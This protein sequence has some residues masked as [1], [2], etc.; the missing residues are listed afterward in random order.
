MKLLMRRAA[1]V[2]VLIASA[3]S[4]ADWTGMQPRAAHAA[5]PTCLQTDYSKPPAAP[6][7]LRFG[8]DPE[9]AGDAGAV[10]LPAVPLNEAAV[11]AAVQGLR[12]PGAPLV[13]RLNRLFESDGPAGIDR[14]RDEVARWSAMGLDSE[15]QVR[16]HP[17][18]A[19]EG[20]LPAWLAYVRRVVDRLGGDRHVIAMT[21]T[22]EVNLPISQNTSDG[23]YRG[24]TQALLE[25]IVAAHDEAAARGF[26]QLQF[27]FTYAYR[28]PEDNSFWQSLAQGGPQFRRDLDW[29]GLDVYPGSVF[30][31]VVV[32]PG[33][34]GAATL[35]ALGVLRRCLM[36]MGQIGARTA[37]WVTENGYP[38]APAPR[39]ENSQSA[40]ISSTVQALCEHGAA[41]GVTDYRYFNVRDNNSTGN[42]LFSAD[43]LLRDDDTHKAAYAVLRGLIAKCSQPVAA[44]G[45]AA[46]ATAN[47]SGRPP[48][49]GAQP[50]S[51]TS[52]R[53][54]STGGVGASAAFGTV[55][56][57]MAAVGARR[58]RP[59]PARL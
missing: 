41:F 9:L 11:G 56:L 35:Q 14:F 33:T 3:A 24:A 59:P 58:S 18:S 10:Q 20:D 55:L 6:V 37:I 45:R 17:T 8:D 50:P 31:P 51:P 16:Y 30:P 47:S 12:S 57:L 1:L 2:I 23:A 27:G 54:A 44:S 29:V 13:Q 15:V 36:P 38:S 52:A 26:S 7:R 40:A 34:E 43:G 46:L 22:N 19:Q 21:I 42:G 48:A 39:S 32:P 25:G 53:L 5:D 28:S 4:A 49:R